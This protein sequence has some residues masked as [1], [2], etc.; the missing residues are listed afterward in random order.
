MYRQCF[1]EYPPTAG[2]SAEP[3]AGEGRYCIWLC[4]HAFSLI[5]FLEHSSKCIAVSLPFLP[6][7]NIGGFGDTKRI[8]T[9]FCRAT[10]KRAP[11]LFFYK[12]SALL[13]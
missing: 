13:C 3:T 10:K 11:N 2:T 4:G 6:L 8:Y 1:M 9:D 12:L 7:A 5:L